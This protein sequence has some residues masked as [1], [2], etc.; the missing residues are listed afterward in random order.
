LLVFKAKLKISFMSS[1]KLQRHIHL[2]FSK[3]SMYLKQNS[4]LLFH[5]CIP[6]EENGEFSELYLE[7]GYYKGKALMDKI[8]N[9]VRVGNIQK[10]KNIK[11]II[12][13]S[14]ITIIKSYFN[15]L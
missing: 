2:L 13:I 3:G 12:Q 1:E 8:E 15:K 11:I 5:A 14:I 7:D 9:I 10:T 6:M 4:N